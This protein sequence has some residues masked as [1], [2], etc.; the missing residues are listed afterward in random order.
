MMVA[1]LTGLNMLVPTAMGSMINGNVQK[2]T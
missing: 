1:L 2:G